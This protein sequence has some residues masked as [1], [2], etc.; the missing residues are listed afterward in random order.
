MTAA[1]KKIVFDS[2]AILKWTQMES[3]YKKVKSLLKACEDGTL[4]GFISQINLGEVYY[5]SIRAVGIERARQFLDNFERLPLTILVPDRGLI[6]KAAEIKAEY[7]ISYADCFAVAT[8]MGLDAKI[9]TGD[10]DFK[11]TTQLVAMEWV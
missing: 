10:P 1:T 4:M 11:K 3:G 5:K 2:H 6:W 8:A 9:V 7:S